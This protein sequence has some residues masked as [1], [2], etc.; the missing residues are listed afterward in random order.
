MI[1]YRCSGDNT[2][3]LVVESGRENESVTCVEEATVTLTNTSK[4][5]KLQ[6][7]KLGLEAKVN[8]ADLNTETA[9]SF[10]LRFKEQFGVFQQ[11]HTVHIVSRACNADNL[12]LLPC[13]ISKLVSYD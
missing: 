6:T 10:S 2:A 9:I 8:W 11:E 4:V 7:T 13:K 12:L 3:K 5:V 1:G